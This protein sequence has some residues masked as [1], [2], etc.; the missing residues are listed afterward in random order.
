MI[1]EHLSKV[2]N[3]TYLSQGLLAHID[4]FQSCVGV[5]TVQAFGRQTNM[6]TFK[7][8]YRSGNLQFF[9]VHS[10]SEGQPTVV[11]DTVGVDETDI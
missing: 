2:S 7:N 1:C 4:N 9:F 10:I 3:A 5:R 11:L 6:S 8:L